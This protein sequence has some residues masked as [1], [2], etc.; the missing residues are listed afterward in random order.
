MV[1]KGSIGLTWN[2]VSTSIGQENILNYYLGITKL[3]CL[4]NSPL[5]KDS[6]PSFGFKYNSDGVI[7][8][9]D[10][11]TGEKGNLLKFLKLYF[12]MSYFDVINKVCSDLLMNSIASENIL[13]IQPKKKKVVIGSD[14]Q[15]KVKI[16]PFR[17]YDLEYWQMYGISEKWLKFGK[18]YAISYFFITKS[19]LTY[20]LPA[21]KYAYVYVERKDGN[22][23]IKI[24]QPFSTQYKWISSHDSSVWDLWDNL[25]KTG[26]NLIIT[27]SRKD[28]LCIWANTGIPATGLQAES[29]LPKEQVI[30]QLKER[31]KNIFVLY[32]ND[33]TKTKNWGQLFGKKLAET[34]GL[35]QIEIPQILQSKDSSDLY[36]NHNVDIFKST[37]KQLINI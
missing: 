22:F 29:Y 15:L 5:R 4:I 6:N 1:S 31:F 23:T 30:N 36:K 25:P 11:S 17:D 32:D 27:S 19:G 10:F 37:I 20:T 35:I 12:D 3:P 18:I 8:F 9:K 26:D 16:R 21:D 14:V 2:D 13:K 24:Y 34:F 7:T 28:A 33:Y